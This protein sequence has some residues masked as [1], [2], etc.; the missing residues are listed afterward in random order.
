MFYNTTFGVA[1]L[2]ILNSVGI[3]AM[4]LGNH[5]FDLTPVALTQALQAAFPTPAAGFPILSANAV[6]TDPS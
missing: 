4:T 3:D 5:E 1:E 6:L 2:Q